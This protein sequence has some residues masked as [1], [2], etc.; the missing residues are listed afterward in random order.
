MSEYVYGYPKQRIDQ[1]KNA[2]ILAKRTFGITDRAIRRELV[3][4]AVG[5]KRQGII[6]LPDDILENFPS[7]A[8]K[9]IREEAPDTIRR[10]IDKYLE[11]KVGNPNVP[12]LID[13]VH[14]IKP[15]AQELVLMLRQNGIEASWAEVMNALEKKEP[16]ELA[17]KVRLIR[18]SYYDGYSGRI[19]KRISELTG[20]SSIVAKKSRGFAELNRHWWSRDSRHGEEVAHEYP[21]SARA[22]LYWSIRDILNQQ[23]RLDDNEKLTDSYTRISVHGMK[24]N[25]FDFA[26]AGGRN[27]ADEEFLQWFAKSLGRELTD[28]GLRP[29]GRE[30]RVVI[31]RTDDSTTK[32]Y[33]GPSSLNVFREERPDAQHPAFGQKFQT[34]QLEITKRVRMNEESRELTVQAVSSVIQKISTRSAYYD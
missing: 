4:D 23:N 22:A 33:A 30:P 26:V 25:D 32:A 10:A 21:R 15:T 1:I 16:S 31:A 6:D 29:R 9:D 18:N 20:A 24:N 7:V 27:P 12:V 5:A 3:I 2:T 14:A 19:A 13:A 34:I 8:Q 11:V 17:E 28:I